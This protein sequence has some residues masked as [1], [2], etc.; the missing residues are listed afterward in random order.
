MIFVLCIGDNAFPPPLPLCTQ[1]EGPN[2]ANHCASAQKWKESASTNTNYVCNY[3]LMV[4]DGGDGIPRRGRL[5]IKHCLPPPPL[6][7]LHL[8]P[9]PIFDPSKKQQ[10]LDQKW[11]KRKLKVIIWGPIQ[12]GTCL[13]RA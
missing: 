13:D 11:M 5:I 12:L 3:C 10:E 2:L 4:R 6:F 7:S 9:Y 8:L 1:T